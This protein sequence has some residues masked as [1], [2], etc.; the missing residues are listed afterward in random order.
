[1][2]RLSLLSLLRALQ[3]P[4]EMCTE[5]RKGGHAESIGMATALFIETLIHSISNNMG[6]NGAYS[7]SLL[8]A[9]VVGGSSTSFNKLPR[10][11]PATKIC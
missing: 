7:I 1:M 11:I 2:T 6:N 5:A 8:D 3:Q 4:E 9:G 10:R